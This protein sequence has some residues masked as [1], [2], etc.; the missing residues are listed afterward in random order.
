MATRLL[1][2]GH[3]L[4]V[5]NRTAAR[6]E[7]L[8]RQGAILFDTPRGA[9]EGA[10]AVIAMLSDDTAS[11]AV[12]L[13]SDGI[14]AANMREH[15]FAIECS[16]L[17][18]DWVTQLATQAMARG[19]RY[20]DAPVTGLPDSAAQGLLTLLAGASEED[21]KAVSGILAAL[22]AKIIRFGPIGTGTAYKLIVNMVGAVQ[23]ASLAEGLAIAE[24]A[25]LDITA[26]GDAFATSQAASPQV[27]RNTRRMV[28]AEHEQNI[29]FSSALRLK[30]IEYGV[31]FARKIGIGSPFGALAE[32]LYR[33]LCE[34][35][36]AR[37]SESKIID[38]CRNSPAE[39]R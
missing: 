29:V 15:A 23:I 37:L 14:L 25:G 13:G 33:Q 38:V 27:I 34:L 21:L 22:S 9:C 18:H 5:Y 8:V 35:G 17:S 3:Q 4:H 36:H 10:D 2:A 7:S 31:R 12:W 1:A 11:R 28:A 16:T 32:R 39:A 20:I 24:R 26:V 6:A 19:L 30:D